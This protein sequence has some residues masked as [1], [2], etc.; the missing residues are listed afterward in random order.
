MQCKYCSGSEAIFYH[1]KYD[2]AFIDNDGTMRVYV[3]GEETKFKVDRCP[4][5]GRLFKGINYLNL[6]SGD[7]IWYANEDENIVEHG[8]IHH[9]SIKNGKIETF[10]V[11]FDCGDF[12]EFDGSGL[13]VHYFMYKVDAEEALVRPVDEF[14]GIGEIPVHNKLCV[15]DEIWYVDVDDAP[16]N[17][18]HAKVE[19]VCMEN[20][21]VEW[22]SVKFDNGDIEEFGPCALGRFCFKS[23]F[24]AQAAWDKKHLGTK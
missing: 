23:Y 14:A 10:S 1:D 13:G 22:F 16:C 3:D 18:E 6:R 11:N 9:V 19:H 15:G 2:C 24:A 8:T 20:E 17:I 12:D 4:M 21:S 7:D 5:C